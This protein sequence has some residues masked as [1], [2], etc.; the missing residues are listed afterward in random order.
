MKTLVP[1]AMFG[2]SLTT[3]LFLSQLCSAQVL[4]S[5]GTYSQNFDTLA[6]TG[7]ANSW[8]DNVT[9][10]GWFAA[11]AKG[12]GSPSVTAYRADD[13][14][15]NSGTVYSYGTTG[16]ANRA[17]GSLGSG[18]PGTQ[19]YGVAFTNDTTDA[20]VDFMIS[21]T[22]EQWRSGSATAATNTLAFA[23]RVSADATIS[24]SDAT[25]T[26]LWTAFTDL[27]F[28]S[29]NV[30]SPAGALL[31]T[32]PTN[33][34]LFVN[35]PLTGVSLQPGQALFIRWMDIDDSGSDHGLGVDNLTV[36]FTATVPVPVSAYVINQPSNQSVYLGDFASFNLQA[37]GDFP[38]TYQWYS[39][40]TGGISLLMDQTNSTLN[41][42]F[43]STTDASGYF[44]AITNAIGGTNSA[45]ATLTV[46]ARTP[47]ATTI[48]HLR[49]L[50]NPITYAPTDTT[51]LYTVQG[52]VT[53]PS[54]MTGSTNA[55]FY[56][57]DGSAGITVFIG[58]GINSLPYAGDQVEV[59]GPLG[60]FFGQ[61]E[62]NT[63]AFNP[64]HSISTLSSFNPLPAPVV[65]DLANASNPAYVKSIESSLVVVSNVF[66]QVGTGSFIS[67]STVNLTNLNNAVFPA[68]ISPYVYDVVANPIPNFAASITGV[69][70]QH[71][72]GSVYTNGF[73]L[74]MTQYSDLVAGTP[75]T[76]PIPLVTGYT[77]GTLTLSWSDPAFILQS[78]T[79]AAG[80]YV[81]VPGAFSPFATNA[82]LSDVPAQ[83]FRLYRTP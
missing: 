1:K 9:L 65:F 77:A 58:G 82:A 6:N 45:V 68:Y 2:L 5:G 51:N 81:D 59:T 14:S 33:Q 25:N 69:L 50:L 10:P 26:P 61:L 47:I 44:C 64:S 79:N 24:D 22:G 75:P 15:A 56:M 35:V 11:K 8:Q 30:G 54:N 72:T 60:Q 48:A 40:N 41:L 7:T 71:A 83:F 53:T 17:L 74:V 70:A 43:V 46:N 80:P 38:I 42:R 12:T 29:P 62:L 49:T 76:L 57:Q 55:Q 18:T 21:Y 34:T 19:F 16:D 13:G 52:I 4:L 32:D 20:M 27:N 23:Y 31:G 39:T 37:G 66:M 67:G 36:S 63:S 28:N 78:S 3:A 73:Q